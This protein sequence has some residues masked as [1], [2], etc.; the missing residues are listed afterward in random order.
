[1]GIVNKSDYL[2]KTRAALEQI[3][4]ERAAQPISN[5]SPQGETLPLASPSVPYTPGN[6]VPKTA[7]VIPQQHEQP[8]NTHFYMSAT[9]DNT[10]IN[11]DVQRLVEEVISNLTCVDGCTVEVT[12]EV[13]AQSPAGLPQSTVRTVSEN[14]R[15]LKVKGFGFDQ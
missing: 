12:L 11:R 5:V 3:N 2:V 13:N 10:R 8:Q 15:T 14:C 1:V 4:A 9:L 7:Q 6:T